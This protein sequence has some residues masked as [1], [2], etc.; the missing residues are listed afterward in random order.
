MER[1]KN[2]K[3]ILLMCDVKF[4]DWFVIWLQNVFFRQNVT[5]NNDNEKSL[6]CR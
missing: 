1:K 6:K 4:F 5:K 2:D 3:D